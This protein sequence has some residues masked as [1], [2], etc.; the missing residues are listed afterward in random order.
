MARAFEILPANFTDKRRPFAF[1][2]PYKPWRDTRG[3]FMNCRSDAC[4]RPLTIVTRTR[5][6][7][8]SFRNAAWV[9]ALSLT[10]SGREQKS[11]SVPSKSRN[12]AMFFAARTR[13]EISS[14]EL[15]TGDIRPADGECVFFWDVFWAR[16][17]LYRVSVNSGASRRISA[18][19]KIRSAAQRYTLCS[20]TMPRILCIRE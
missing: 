15:K 16:C 12:R 20:F 3:V 6:C 1:S 18:S 14:Q 2:H 13:R 17:T 4:R 10:C 8:A 5:G 9:R 7:L 19:S 11:T